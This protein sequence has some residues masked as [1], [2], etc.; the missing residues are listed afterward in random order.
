LVDADNV[1]PVRLQPVLDLLGVQYLNIDLL[2]A[3][4]QR[5]LDRLRWPNGATVLQASGWQRAD[6]VLAEGYSP[7]REPL[8]LI[9]GDG[10]FGLLAARHP[11][12]VLVVSGSPSGRLRDVA[13]T[14]DPAVDGLTPIIDWLL[15]VGSRPVPPLWT[16]RL[17]LRPRQVS[18]ANAF[19]LLFADPEVMRYV[20]DGSPYSRTPKQHLQALERDTK[21]QAE[22]GFSL[23]TVLRRTDEQVLGFTGLTPW[24]ESDEI[25]V[26]WRLGREFWGQGYATEA[27]RAALGYGLS[28][29]GLN[30]VIS[31]GQ[32]DNVASLHIMATIG[33]KFEAE[34]TLHG[35]TAHRYAIGGTRSGR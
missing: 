28:M 30:R 15:A 12:P 14:V 31:V 4:H 26:G 2:A 7:D 23:F 9:T 1:F 25:E 22:R 20:G 33:L 18:D 8:L 35:R 29:C 16:P 21:T 17:M 34:V 19:D 5:S 10:D 24:P 6:V 27:A 11:G 3:G 13:A 32:V